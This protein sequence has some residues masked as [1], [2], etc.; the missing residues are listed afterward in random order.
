M[1]NR[2]QLHVVVCINEDGTSYIEPMT[3]LPKS[4]DKEIYD[5]RTGDWINFYNV[6]EESKAYLKE[7]LENLKTLLG[8][9][10]D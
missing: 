2:F 6:P 7:G 4:S 1:Q 5:I 8:D 3:I 10:N 9:G